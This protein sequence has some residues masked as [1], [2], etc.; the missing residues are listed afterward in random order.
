MKLIKCLHLPDAYKMAWEKVGK[1][2]IEVCF[3]GDF[4]EYR[5]CAEAQL[6]SAGLQALRRMYDKKN[7]KIYITYRKQK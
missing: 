7:N 6:K 4:N 2:Y 1:N 3:H 5:I